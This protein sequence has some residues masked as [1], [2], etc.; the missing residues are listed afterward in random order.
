MSRLHQ[1]EEGLKAR[2]AKLSDQDANLADVATDQGTERGRLAK[3]KAEANKAQASHAWHVSE[4][5]AQPEAREKALIAAEQKAATDRETF[6]ALELG[7]RKVLRSIC[8]GG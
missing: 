7:F 8:E 4:A 2:E 3:L 6:I 1:Q 5:T